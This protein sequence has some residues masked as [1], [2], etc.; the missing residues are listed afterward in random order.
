MLDAE[1]V[2]QVCTESCYRTSEKAKDKI[3]DA[4]TDEMGRIEIY[5]ALYPG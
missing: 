3:E 4:F 5:D 1:E 2:G